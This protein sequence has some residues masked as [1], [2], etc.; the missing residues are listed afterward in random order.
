M[1]T[2]T[3]QNQIVIKM[4]TENEKKM[5]PMHLV[6]T[7]AAGTIAGMAVIFTLFWGVEKLIGM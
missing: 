3:N 2:K 1:E 7:L 4:N 5:L 6:L